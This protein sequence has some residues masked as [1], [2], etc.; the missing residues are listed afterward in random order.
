MTSLINN[1]TVRYYSSRFST[2]VLY[3]LASE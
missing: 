1:S 2:W 3:M